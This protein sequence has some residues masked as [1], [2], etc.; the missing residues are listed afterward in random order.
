MNAE[1]FQRA[2]VVG[3]SGEDHAATFDAADLL[4]RQVGDDDELLADERCWI[5]VE[6]ADATDDGAF[7]A[8]NV[9]GELQ[10]LVGFF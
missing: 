3:G 8:A 7:F 2:V 1:H 10:E 5:V 4:W 6:F 9:E